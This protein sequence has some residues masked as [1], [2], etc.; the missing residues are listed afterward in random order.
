MILMAVGQAVAAQHPNVRLAS[1]TK[2][3]RISLLAIGSLLWPDLQNIIV[4]TPRFLKNHL[5]PPSLRTFKWLNRY[6]EKQK[7]LT[8]SL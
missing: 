5:P 6:N 1:K 8:V 7:C 4:I 3:P 2:G